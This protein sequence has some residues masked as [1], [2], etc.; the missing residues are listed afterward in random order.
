MNLLKRIL[1]VYVIP[2]YTIFCQ[3]TLLGTPGALNIPANLRNI[4]ELVSFVIDTNPIRTG[5]GDFK[6]EFH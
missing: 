3:K 4:D 2:L 6:G 1:I 5:V